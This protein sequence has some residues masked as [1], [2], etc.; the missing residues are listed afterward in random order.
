[1]PRRPGRRRRGRPAPRHRL[2]RR[3]HWRNYNG[4]PSPS[5][6]QCTW[7]AR[8]PAPGYRRKQRR[9]GRAWRWRCPPPRRRSRPRSLWTR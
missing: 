7:P 6:R 9:P 1:M 5:R 2:R 8:R 4:F 3:S